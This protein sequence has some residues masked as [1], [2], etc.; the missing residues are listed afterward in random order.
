MNHSPR[1]DFDPA[2]LSDAAA[3]FAGLAAQKLDALAE[4]ATS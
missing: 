4:E 2:V 3:V 1:A